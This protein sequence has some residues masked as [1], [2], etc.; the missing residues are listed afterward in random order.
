MSLI[1]AGQTE[2]NIYRGRKMEIKH[3]VIDKDGEPMD[4]STYTVVL[5]IIHSLTDPHSYVEIA[6]EFVT[7]GSDGK[8]SFF[9]EP[10]HT[11]D[12][13]LGAYTISTIVIDDGDE[14]PAFVGRMGLIGVAPP[15]KEES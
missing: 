8:V 13:I 14:Y 6:G 7:D 3:L 1:T 10:E 9:L 4:V 12:L 2:F 5:R 15:T 11:E